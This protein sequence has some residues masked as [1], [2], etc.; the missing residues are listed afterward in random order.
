SA[1]VAPRSRIRSIRHALTL[2]GVRTVRRWTM[3][4]ML[5]GRHGQPHELLVTA[6]V[7]AR[8]CE[9]LAGI[10]PEAETDRA[11]TA[12]LFSIA[13]ALLHTPLQQLLDGLPFDDR[14][15][16]ALLDHTGPEGRILRAVLA[17]ERGRFPAVAQEHDLAAFGHAYYDS[18]S[19]ATEMV[20]ALN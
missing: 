3:L 9:V 12:G 6:L 18:V 4:L 15:T 8:L 14:L 11:F 2:L 13:D 19:W 7:R 5:A 1:H 16:G 17:Y 10:D 20:V